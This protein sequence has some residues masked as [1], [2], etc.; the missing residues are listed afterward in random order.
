M[1][2]LPGIFGRIPSVDPRY[3]LYT[4]QGL[5]VPRIGNLAVAPMGSNVQFFTRFR[6]QCLVLNGSNT[7]T[8][9]HNGWA[10]VQETGKLAMG[11]AP[12]CELHAAK[13]AAGHAGRMV[14]EG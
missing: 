8:N 11:F 5:A 1:A 4:Q 13:V 7:Q 12:L 3:N 6:D 14:A 10:R 9:S 2:D